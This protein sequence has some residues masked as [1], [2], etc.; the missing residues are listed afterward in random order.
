MQL[1]VSAVNRSGPFEATATIQGGYDYTE[2]QG[3]AAGHQDV[4]W[5]VTLRQTPMGWKIVALR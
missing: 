3:G 5:A 4:S 2:M 1:N